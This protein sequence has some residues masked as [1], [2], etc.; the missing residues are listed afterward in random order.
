MKAWVLNKIGDIQ[1][2]E[3]DKPV[4]NE[5]EVLIAVKAAGICGSD[6]PRIYQTGAHSMPLVLG[7]EFAG[8]VVETGNAVNSYWLNKRVGVFPLIPCGKCIACQKKQYEM[9]RKYDYLGSRSNGGFAEYVK[10]PAWNLIELPNNVTYYDAAM[11][12][13]TAVA[14]HAIRQLNVE[15]MNN[16]VVCGLGTIGMLIAMLLIARG[17][18]NIYVIGNKKSQKQMAVKLG[19]TKD[20]YCDVNSENVSEWINNHTGGAGA[21]AFFECVG[22]NQTVSLAIDNA[23]PGGS[24]CLVGNPY[25]DMFLD[26]QVYWKV[27]RNQLKI[28]GTWNSSFSNESDDDWHSVV[29]LLS[30][31]HIKPSALITH[32]YNLYDLDNGFNIMHD[33]LE[34]YIKILAIM[35]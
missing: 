25:T 11:L 8:K 21:D 20:N 18:D 16:V 3:V 34:D 31:G 17:A 33:K 35:E 13:P 6:I 30:S 2:Q 24:I 23:A 7:H 15:K 12:E 27:L 1:Y 9:C 28:N 4:I 10:V 19:I 29:N 26:K 14:Y 22:K 32:K 5:D